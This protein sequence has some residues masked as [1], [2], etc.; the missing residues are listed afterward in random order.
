MGPSHS[1]VSG[2]SG[3]LFAKTRRR[4]LGLL[5]GNPGRSYFANEIGLFQKSDSDPGSKHHFQACQTA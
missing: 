5:Y 4:V 2:L 3:A 1:R